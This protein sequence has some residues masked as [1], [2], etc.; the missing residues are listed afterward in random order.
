MKKL[1][2]VV[3]TMYVAA[4]DEEQVKSERVEL[5][6]CELK[7]TLAKKVPDDWKTASPFGG[8]GINNCQEYLENQIDN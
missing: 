5:E 6:G 1:Y 2:K 7:I 8:N 4:I 3:A